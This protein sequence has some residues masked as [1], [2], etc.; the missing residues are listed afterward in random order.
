MW[1]AKNGFGFS[2]VLNAMVVPI[3]Y[4]LENHCMVDKQRNMAIVELNAGFIDILH[5]FDGKCYPL[6]S[7][8]SNRPSVSMQQ[9]QEKIDFWK[10]KNRTTPATHD[11][12]LLKTNAH[13][14][15]KLRT[16]R[17]RSAVA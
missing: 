7:S 13:A 14:Q 11:L 3:A 16:R 4:Y 2:D 17:V 15:E 5:V 12:L 9:I 8:V 1:C 10:E 6:A